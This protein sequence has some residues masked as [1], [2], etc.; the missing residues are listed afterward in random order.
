ME[1]ISQSSPVARKEHQCMWCSGVIKKGEKYEK[2]TYKYVDELYTWKNHLKCT[3]L[4]EE[5]NMVDN[6]DGYGIDSNTFSNCVHDFLLN[7]YSY[8]KIEDLDLCDENAVDE[9]LEILKEVRNER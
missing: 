7:H 6:D 3:K 1:M 5:L 8:E 4:Y 9:A 2:S